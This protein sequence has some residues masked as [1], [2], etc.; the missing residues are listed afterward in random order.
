M[1][2]LYSLI[3][4]E[5]ACQLIVSQVVTHNPAGLL[6]GNAP[7]NYAFFDAG[8][9]EPDLVLQPTTPLFE[10][11]R[12]NMP[13][14][15]HFIGPILPVFPL[16]YDEPDWWDDL[17]TDRPVVL[18]T[19]GTLAADP[20]QLIVP[21]IQALADQAVLVVVTTANRPVAE[22]GHLPPN[23]R[24]APFI[25]YDRL[26]PHIDLL[27]TNG[28]YGAVQLAL[29]YGVPL[30]AAGKT[31]EK[32]EICARIAWAGVGINL[33]TDTPI[34]NEQLAINKGHRGY[35]YAC[36]GSTFIVTQR[37]TEKA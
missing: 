1:V 12:P 18:V 9:L 13:D 3:P 6:Y 8:L 25:P 20:R 11:P 15:L 32:A 24:A 10:Y 37:A 28:G 36:P 17:P 26:L 29:A 31:E 22:L 30:V 5:R 7:L 19:Q 34:K 23:V 33:R 4:L 21:A 2:M 27:V 35:I 14:T 16:A